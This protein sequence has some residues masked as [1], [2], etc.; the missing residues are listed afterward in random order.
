MSRRVQV[1]VL[2]A[3]ALGLGA[4]TSACEE[5]P[6]GAPVDTVGESGGDVAG[7]GGERGARRRGG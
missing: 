6:D 4:P 1:V 3:V 5:S 2:L 7:A